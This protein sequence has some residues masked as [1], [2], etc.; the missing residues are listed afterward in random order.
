MEMERK[1]EQY[2]IKNFD[3]MSCEDLRKEVNKKFGMSYKTTAF[4]Y[5]TKRLGLSKHI[6]HHYTQE[7]DEFLRD[8]SSKMTRKELTDIFNE[9]YGT[10]IKEQAIE[11]RCFLRGWKPKTDGKFKEGSV[12]WEKTTGGREEYVKK[13][14]GGNSTSFRKGNIPHNV[15]DIGTIRLWGHELKIKTDDGWKNRLR[16][17]W[18]QE[19]GSIPD[20]YVII[21][22]D[23]DKYT[24]D[25]SKLRLIKNDIL[26]ILM[27][28]DWV[29]KGELIVDTGIVWGDL[30]R[31][32]E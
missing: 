6:E 9:R 7:Q 29:G 16:H 27:A 25:T 19:H 5:H 23:G 24:K 22:V 8:N 12:P 3:E 10:A 18:E 21:S 20:G 26:T 31:M 4:H 2:I 15:I 11:Q 1:I 17:L 30:Y 13:L 28:N 32:L 14:K